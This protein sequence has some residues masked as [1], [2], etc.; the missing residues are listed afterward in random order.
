MSILYGS[1]KKAKTNARLKMFQYPLRIVILKI[2]SYLS[3]EFYYGQAL[4]LCLLLK[5]GKLDSSQ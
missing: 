2:I 3:R 4:P 5:Y 1:L